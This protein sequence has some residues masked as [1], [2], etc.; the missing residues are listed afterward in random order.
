MG[1]E[2]LRL[3]LST[4]GSADLVRHCAEVKSAL[5]DLAV[6]A[7]S[8]QNAA[9]GALDEV[10][11]K[12]QELFD[13]SVR[14]RAAWEDVAEASLEYA[15]AL[16]EVRAA[17]EAATKEATEDNISRLAKAMQ[18]A[19]G[20]HEKLAAAQKATGE[21]S[22]SLMGLFERL[23]TSI[24]GQVGVPVG[25]VTSTFGEFESVLA[26]TGG[27]IGIVIAACAALTVGAYEMGAAFAQNARQIATQADLMGISTTQYQLLGEASERAGLGAEAG[28]YGMLMLNMELTR[29]LESG[30]RHADMLRKLGIAGMQEGEAADVLVSKLMDE[31]TADKTAAEM[32]ELLGRRGMMLVEVLKQEAEMQKESGKSAAEFRAEHEKAGDVI[33]KFGIQLGEDVNGE[34]AKS[35]EAWHAI[36]NEL[37]MIFAP[38]AAT[39]AIGLQRL[40]EGLGLVLRPLV[41]LEHWFDKVLGDADTPAKVDKQAE[42]VKALGQQLA[43]LQHAESEASSRGEN[44][45]ATL[46]AMTPAIQVLRNQY[47]ALGEEVP[48]AL[49]KMYHEALRADEG[50]KRAEEALAA[51]KKL[52][53]AQFT[54]QEAAIKRAHTLGETTSEQELT[55]LRTLNNMKLTYEEDYYNR[56]EALAKKMAG[57]KG[58]KADLTSIEGERAAVEEKWAAKDAELRGETAAKRKAQDEAMARED[59]AQAKRASEDVLAVDE[60]TAKEQ[61]ANREINAAAYARMLQDFARR[62]T[63]IEKMALEGELAETI[64]AGGDNAA[65]IKEIQDKITEIIRKG[66]LD[67][68]KARQEGNHLIEADEK[69]T[70]TAQV[71]D[72]NELAKERLS[73][74]RRDIDQEYAMNRLSASERRAQQ[75]AAIDEEYRVEESGVAAQMALLKAW[76]KEATAEYTAYENQLKAL[77]RKRIADEADVN[78]QFE[79]DTKKSL[80]TASRDF[81]A[82]VTRW[83][84]SHKGLAAQSARLWLSMSQQGVL[85]IKQLSTEFNSAV[86]SWAM[87]QEK[88]SKAIMQS[89]MALS[90]AVINY[91]LQMIETWIVESIL[92]IS[93][94]KSAAM[95]NVMAEAGVAG[96]AQYANVMMAVPFPA[97]LPLAP[98]MAM[99]AMAQTISIGSAAAGALTKEEMVAVLHPHEMV[100]PAHISTPLQAALNPA[101]FRPS[102]PLTAPTSTMNTRNLRLNYAPQISGTN[103]RELED[104]SHR[105]SR[106]LSQMMRRELRRG[107]LP[108]L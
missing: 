40:A 38:I 68:A 19:A 56:K 78:R 31:N 75:L 29:G 32:K 20:A 96:A 37:G 35:K 103:K 85:S 59:V 58:E 22:S 94:H 15:S 88:F 105:H 106:Q 100:L 64:K 30:G 54:A 74:R 44:V 17:Q 93:Q 67:Q 42:A 1:A 72:A 7:Q 62:R 83:E 90:K 21:S 26:S 5:H 108:S 81:D 102:A 69:R 23:G 24:G 89:W 25:Q 101:S 98:A 2:P 92:G 66:A 57:V 36:S 4:D 87:G 51:E 61:Y 107:G 71:A 45:K 13:A 53:D 47:L 97:N 27:E 99:A 48:A 63:D 12:T 70:L 52:R 6:E 80:D 46:A 3:Q 41:G 11:K 95:A 79:R 28:R 77:E 50:P 60:F 84:A 86:T 76:H 34:L 39:V 33:D 104:T 73:I 82:F 55:Q 43:V 10:V 18:G 14:T 16:K 49:D 91:I 8:T 9:S 65:K